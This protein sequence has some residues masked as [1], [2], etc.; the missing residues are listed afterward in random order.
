LNL[1]QIDLLEFG[2][3]GRL[4]AVFPK[5]NAMKQVAWAV[6]ASVAVWLAIQ[7]LNPGPEIRNANPTGGPV[8]CFGDSLTYGT[9]AGEGESYPDRLGENLGEEVINA[10][11]PGDTTAEALARLEEDV[12][13]HDPRAVFITL[14]GNDLKNGLSK[15]SAFR[16]LKIIVTEIQERGALVVL[17]GVNVPFWGRGFGEAYR[18]LAEETGAVLIP[19]VLDGLMGKSH[20]MSDTIHPNAAGYA[21]MAERFFA[22]AEPYL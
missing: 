12:L 11:V 18:E 5:E 10:G 2:R 3:W 20:L 17:G 21:I 9:G 14:G 22:A 1:L 19:N 4:P 15:E 13:I 7:W 8:V 16:N 6:A